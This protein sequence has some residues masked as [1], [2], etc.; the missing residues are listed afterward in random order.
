MG[1]TMQNDYKSLAQDFAMI[2]PVPEVIKAEHVSVIKTAQFDS[3][4]NYTIPRLVEYDRLHRCRK[5]VPMSAK[6]DGMHRDLDVKVEAEFS[7]SEYDLVV[8]SAKKSA[9][10]MTWLEREKYNLPAGGEGAAI[11]W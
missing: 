8:F 5:S 7:V 4:I 10:L 2:V 1:I 11:L 6:K 3:L 9:D